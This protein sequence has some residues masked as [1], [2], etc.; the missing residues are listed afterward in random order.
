M[1]F[2]TTP[3]IIFL[4]ASTVGFI[5]SFSNSILM[6]RMEKKDVSHTRLMI[7]T[8][9]NSIFLLAIQSISIFGEKIIDD[10]PDMGISSQM[11]SFVLIVLNMALCV[12]LMVLMPMIKKL[13]KSPTII[14]LTLVTVI[15]NILC[16]LTY[17][18]AMEEEWFN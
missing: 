5:S 14:A 13:E 11:I 3:G 1:G 4:I 8:Y 15:C 17:P 2:Y 18:F 12:P 16:F 7:F 6:H 9:I 10:D